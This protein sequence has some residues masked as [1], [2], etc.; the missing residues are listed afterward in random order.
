MKM[1]CTTARRTERWATRG[2]LWT[3]VALLAVLGLAVWAGTAGSSGPPEV[4][5]VSPG[6]VEAVE[7][8]DRAVVVLTPIGAEKIGLEL[9][10]VTQVNHA[11][12]NLAVPFA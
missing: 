3:L 7:G 11:T 8:S 10:N 1:P 5:H 6:T 9:R 12:G 2:G 4:Q